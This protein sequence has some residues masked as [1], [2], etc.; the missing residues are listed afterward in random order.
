MLPCQ[1][2]WSPAP[3]VRPD[4]EPARLTGPSLGPL[5]SARM[6]PA[7]TWHD[8]PTLMR[9]TGWSWRWKA[10]GGLALAVVLVPLVAWLSLTHQPRFYRVSRAGTKAQREA[11]ARHFVANSMQLRNDI[12]N[13]RIWQAT[14]TDGEVNAWL[15][16]DL[17]VHFADQI[18]PEIHDPRIAFEPDR[19]TFA[20]GLDRGPIRSV[21]WAVARLSVPEE[22]VLAVAVEKV[23][24]GVIPLPVDRVMA[25]L[26]ALARDRGLDIRWRS[27]QSP[28]VALIRYRPDQ[29]RS[30]VVLQRLVVRQG[31]L[32]ISGRSDRLLGAFG[33]PILPDRRL[34]QLNFPNRKRQ[35]PE[36]PRVRG[37]VP[38]SS[39]QNLT[40]PNS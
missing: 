35:G 39:S 28:P 9:K 13:E 3:Q 6:E 25:P 33:G 21:I 36:A 12:T 1:G 5:A 10:L 24:A 32:R 16:E 11:R 26:S 31:Q 8:G 27:D 23:R 19:V 4:L 30:D 14:F 38:R 29:G 15:A 37:T 17:L 34:L 22:N 18:P 2:G 20:F 40:V 7:T